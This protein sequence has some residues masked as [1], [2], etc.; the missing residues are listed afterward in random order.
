MPNPSKD[1][2][3]GAVDIVA[4]IGERVALTRKGKDYV[5]LCPFHPDHKPSM[6]V[7]P[8]KQI[9][10]CWS[11]GVG[12]DAIK[13]IQLRDRVEF[14]DALQTLARWAGMEFRQGSYDPRAV[15]IREQLLSALTWAAEHF[16]HNL[17]VADIGRS[18]LAYTKKRQFDA[19]SLER[20]K[21]GFAADAWDDLFRAATKAG[22]PE[23][24]LQQ[25]GLITV[26]DKGKRYDRFR[27]RLMFPIAD[28]LGRIVAF[29][30]RTLGDDPA[31]YLNSPETALFSKSR[32]LYGL[33]L[34]R[35]AIDPK[36]GAIVV[37]GYTDAVLLHQYGFTNVVATLGTA[38][39]DA[40]VKLLRPLSDTMILCFDGDQ[41]GIKA[42]DR[43]VEIALR[44][45]MDVRVATLEP[46]QDPADCVISAG[47]DGFRSMLQSA[48]PALEFKWLITETAFGDG[49]LADRRSAVNEFLQFVAR[50][51]HA[52]KVD[53]VEQGL[54]VDRL[55]GLLSVPAGAVYEMLA[56]VQ[57]AGPRHAAPSTSDEQV[58]S[59]YDVST[60]G[61]PR[62]VIVAVEEVFG[63]LLADCACLKQVEDFAAT[64]FERCEPWRLLYEILNGLDQSLEKVSKRNV[65]EA[66]D[67]AAVLELITRASRHVDDCETDAS[68]RFAEAQDRLASELEVHRMAVLKNDLGG[69]D[70]SSRESHDAFVSYFETAIRQN[71][72][73]SPDQRIGASLPSN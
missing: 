20:H 70:A 54:L 59:A 69:A 37:E 67:D 43:A 66:C 58:S 62:D 55:S 30:G 6:S 12:G 18:A 52:G 19:A 47:S 38:L 33:D 13:Y 14:R 49:G 25:A 16:R 27:N 72:P 15:Q 73:F 24:V 39:T 50:V 42:A 28:A 71:G 36:S 7:S 5:G 51:C 57:S 10:K 17:T 64:A 61:A 68:G 23:D 32:V 60:Q 44:N 46:G 21:I 65:I 29:G 48:K 8:T 63:W 3:L 41:A 2:I 11:C 45:R 22:I 56:G 1:S 4:L 26:S 53:P 31:K 40:H 9:F 35:P 34:A